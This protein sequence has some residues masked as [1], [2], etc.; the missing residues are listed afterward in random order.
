[1]AQ[2]SVVALESPPSIYLILGRE[3][4]LPVEVRDATA[5]VAYYLVPAAAAQRLVTPSALRVALVLPGRTL[6]TIG[7]MDYK[8][9]DLGQYHEIAVTF[10]VH[11]RDSRPLPFIGTALG[12]LRGNVGAYIHRL[13]VDGEFTCE[14]GRTI[15][16]FPKFVTEIALSSAGGEQTAVLRADGQHVLTHTVRT[17][18]TR[19]LRNRAQIS[20]GHRDGVV[21]K[22]LAVM[23]GEGVGARLGG[24]RLELGTHPLAGE[25]RAL[26]LPK[27][28]LFSTYMSKMT[29]TFYAAERLQ[30]ARA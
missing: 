2:D 29:G 9:G 13:P 18:G 1:M 25:L 26:G 24:A 20:Y 16:G 19:V 11:E 21:Y 5:A 6:C 28:P 30:P 15:W 8:D 27:R 10:F 22:T 17:G 23:S 7:T 12:L 4:R 14:A 3:V